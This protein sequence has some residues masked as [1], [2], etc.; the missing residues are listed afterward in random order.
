MQFFQDFVTLQEFGMRN[1]VSLR[2]LYNEE[3]KKSGLP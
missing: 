2:S 1:K 3:G